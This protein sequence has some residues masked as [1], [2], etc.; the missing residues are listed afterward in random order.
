MMIHPQCIAVSMCD[1][2]HRRTRTGALS[3]LSAATYQS[4]PTSSPPI[5]FQ[6]PSG[7]LPEST[8]NPL[9]LTLEK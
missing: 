6:P 2:R 4:R 9:D 1:L 7:T 3:T 8:S 5:L